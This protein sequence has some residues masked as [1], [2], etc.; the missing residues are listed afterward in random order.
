MYRTIE[1]VKAA[2]TAN[3]NF[4]TD[5]LLKSKYFQNTTRVSD[6]TYLEPVT[7]AAVDS[8]IS[9]ASGLGYSLMVFETYRSP[10]RQQ[11]LFSQGST[12]LKNVGVHH[13]GLGCDI[14]FDDYGQPSWQGNFRLLGDLARKH[15]LVWGG[16]WGEST[17]GHFV[18]M[19]H[20]QRISVSDQEKLFAGSW[21]PDEH[22]IPTGVG[23]RG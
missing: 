10:Q 6:T 8:I 1:Q 15:G 16:D 2:P 13:Y 4:Y 11:Y 9:D 17:P 18:D 20:V 5:F 23:Y 14:V 7:R 19:D 22:Y 21:Y 12:Q 3:G